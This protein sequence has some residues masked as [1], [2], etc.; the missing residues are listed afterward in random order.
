[1]DQTA[2]RLTKNLTYQDE[3]SSCQGKHRYISREAAASHGP[4]KNP[5]RKKKTSTDVYRCQW[6]GFFHCGNTRIVPR[7]TRKEREL[8]PFEI[9]YEH[10]RDTGDDDEYEA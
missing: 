10:E 5:G 6:C 1:M 7:P 8:T 3:H 2:S 4:K 9:W